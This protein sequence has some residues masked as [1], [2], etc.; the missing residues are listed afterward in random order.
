MGI[1]LYESMFSRETELRGYVYIYNER[2][3]LRNWLTQLWEL[4]SQKSAAQGR[5]N[6]AASP[7]P[8]GGRI[9]SSSGS[10]PSLF[11]SGLQL[12]G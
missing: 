3:V 4:K 10:S 6:A 12:I 5:V 9:S 7:K 1:R 2:F 8:S 11:S